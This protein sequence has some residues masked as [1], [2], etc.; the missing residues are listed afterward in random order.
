MDCLHRNGTRPFKN[1][2]VVLM[3]FSTRHYGAQCN[4]IY[5]TFPMS[6]KIIKGNALCD[7]N[8]YRQHLKCSIQTKQGSQ[9][10]YTKFHHHRYSLDKLTSTIEHVEQLVSVDFLWRSEKDDLQKYQQ[11]ASP[12]NENNGQWKRYKRHAADVSTTPANAL[13]MVAGVSETSATCR[14]HYFH[15]PLF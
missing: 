13:M 1:L 2:L 8:H 14:L 15:W 4:P 10:N 11:L 9:W 7:Y 5:F 3:S 6:W 12:Y